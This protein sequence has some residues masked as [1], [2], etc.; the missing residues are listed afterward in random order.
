MSA[1]FSRKVIV[2]LEESTSEQELKFLQWVNANRLGWAH[3]FRGSWLL[4]IAGPNPTVQQVV[5]HIQSME[6]S[7][8]CAVFEISTPNAWQGFINGETIEGARNWFQTQWHI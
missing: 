3:W 5:E 7:P 6:G 1:A 2:L 8:Q 4:A